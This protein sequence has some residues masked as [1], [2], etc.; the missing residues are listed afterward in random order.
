[1]LL[2]LAFRW[3]LLPVLGI[4]TISLLCVCV[5]VELLCCTEDVDEVV[6]FVGLVDVTPVVLEDVVLDVLK[7]VWLVGPEL[8]P[9]A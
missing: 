4:Q 5:T 8:L 9:V 7:E 1:M 3:N 2:Q 6:S